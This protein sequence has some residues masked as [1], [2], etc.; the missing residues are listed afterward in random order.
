MEETTGATSAWL[1][2]AAQDAQAGQ[3]VLVTSGG[4]QEPTVDGAV[5]AGDTLVAGPNGRV[6]AIGA[7]TD[8]SQV[9]GIALT[10]QPTAGLLCRARFIR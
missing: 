3:K 5:T 1:G 2:I 10:S 8:Y 4:V 6:T 9:V 7:G